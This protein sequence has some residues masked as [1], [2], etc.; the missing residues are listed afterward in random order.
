[1]TND[2]LT[3]EH[4]ATA[5]L[6]AILNA[7]DYRIGVR[8][9]REI[10]KLSGELEEV[11]EGKAQTEL[12]WKLQYR[13]VRSIEESMRYHTTY[14]PCTYPFRKY[15]A[16]THKIN[17]KSQFTGNPPENLVL[18][19]TKPPGEEFVRNS[20]PNQSIVPKDFI[21]DLTDIF[22]AHFRIKSFIVH[23]GGYSFGHYTA[24]GDRDGAWRHYDDA[25]VTDFSN[26]EI[27][28]RIKKAYVIVCEKCEKPE[29]AS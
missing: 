17:L 28:K 10:F 20:E 1:L 12:M 11:S 23:S 2:L 5:S 7:L 13:N 8:E 29:I 9:D 15:T 19:L 6:E 4:D 25:R 21:F 14:Q 22:G 27:M 18:F 3:D 24:Y 16:E 26:E